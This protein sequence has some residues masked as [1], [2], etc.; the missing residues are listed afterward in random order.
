VGVILT[1]DSVFSEAQSDS[2]RNKKLTGVGGFVLGL[3]FLVVGV[4]V[5]VRSKKGEQACHLAE[6]P[7]TLSYCPSPQ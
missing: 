6:A 5:H 7:R 4:V 3:I 2:A 1:L